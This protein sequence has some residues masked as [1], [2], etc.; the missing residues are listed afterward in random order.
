MVFLQV[1]DTSTIVFLLL[2]K[3]FIPLPYPSSSHPQNH[4]NDYYDDTTSC[5]NI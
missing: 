2:T 3:F 5:P 1:S 4:I